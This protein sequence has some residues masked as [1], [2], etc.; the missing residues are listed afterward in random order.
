VSQDG[1]SIIIDYASAI[2][3]KLVVVRDLGSKGFR[4]ILKLFL[5]NNK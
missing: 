4:G 5:F 1:L 2:E 3:K